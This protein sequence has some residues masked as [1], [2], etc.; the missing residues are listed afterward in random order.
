M[1]KYLRVFIFLSLL[2]SFSIA[3]GGALFTDYG[4]LR[5][6]VRRRLLLYSVELMP[7]SIMNPLISEA[8][9][10]TSTDAGGCY[11][12]VRQATTAAQSF[13][14]I[15]DSVVRIFNASIIGIGGLK[16]KDLRY[17]PTGYAEQVIGISNLANAADEDNVPS[18]YSYFSDTVQLFPPP[19]RVDSIF[20]FCQV[21]HKAASAGD[22]TIQLNE[23]FQ[24]PLVEYTCYLVK[25]ALT[26]HDEAALYLQAYKEK[27]ASAQQLY[28]PI[29]F[30]PKK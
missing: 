8:L 5:N 16:T 12:T 19:S 15:P 26:L 4:S 3:F 27:K 22:S 30:A 20:F 29:T 9:L 23:A 18:G 14:A 7:D 24:F 2:F 1:V 17:I 6:D 10:F 11:S 21:E 25:K 13:Y 28:T